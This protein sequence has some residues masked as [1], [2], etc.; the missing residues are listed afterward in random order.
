MFTVIAGTVIQNGAFST[1][2]ANKQVIIL[3]WVIKMNGD[4]VCFMSFENLTHF[5][6]QYFFF[7]Y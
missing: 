6:S 2:L 5:Y 7:L 3:G 1:G 4:V